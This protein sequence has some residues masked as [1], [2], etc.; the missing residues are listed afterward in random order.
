MSWTAPKTWAVGEVVTAANMNT[1]LRDNLK[2]I[3]DAW[4]SW[5]PTWTNITVGNGAVYAQ[6]RVSGKTTDFEIVL[7]FGSTT[8][9]TGA[10]SV[11]LP[12]APNGTA[13][14]AI[15][16]VQYYD[17]SA[18]QRFAGWGEYASSSNLVL[19]ALNSGA[20]TGLLTNLTATV[21]FTW[22]VGDIIAIRGTLESA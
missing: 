15:D 13:R 18:A 9:V 2:A 21:P 7:T 22:A 6:E 1:H 19:L 12:V 20:A 10:A 4:A 5:T 8:S 14:R 11:T 16:A 3:G 17:N